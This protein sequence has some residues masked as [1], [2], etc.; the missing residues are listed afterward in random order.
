MSDKNTPPEPSPTVQ[1]DYAIAAP[2]FFV[3]RVKGK[4]SPE[5]LL[6]RTAAGEAKRNPNAIGDEIISAMAF[7]IERDQAL[8]LQIGQMVLGGDASTFYRAE[9]IL[10]AVKELKARVQTPNIEP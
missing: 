7:R 3:R 8:I 6:Q 9:D 5:V 2:P 10:N 4:K 1:Y